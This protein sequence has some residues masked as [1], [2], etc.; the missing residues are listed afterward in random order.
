V[1]DVN[2]SMGELISN[3]IPLYTCRLLVF[4]CLNPM[5]DYSLF[6]NGL[7]IAVA[8]GRMLWFLASKRGKVFIGFLKSCRRMTLRKCEYMLKEYCM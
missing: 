2:I 5:Y 4:K 7:R 3:F 6:L 8:V 1:G